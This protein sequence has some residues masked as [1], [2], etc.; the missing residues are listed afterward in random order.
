MRLILASGSPRRAEI[1]T[2]LGLEFIA[3]ATDVDESR[4]PD[5]P[6][7]VYTER[8]AREKAAMGAAPDMLSIGCDTVVVHGGKVLGKP[9][10]PEEARNMLRRLQGDVHEV[11]TALAV[12]GWRDGALVVESAVDVT[13]VTLLPMTEV[14]IADY[15]ASGEPM[16]KAGAY[17]LQ[18]YGGVFVESI[19]G[20]A[21]T[22]VGMPVH[23]LPRLVARFG[24]TLGAFREAG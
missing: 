24:Q 18:E 11:V 6:P 16:D 3:E 1:L 20:S 7:P 19:V 9:G 4:R 14:E 17:A 5:E 13:E 21:H 15:V 8:L 2:A 10:H 22:V 12:A 23:L